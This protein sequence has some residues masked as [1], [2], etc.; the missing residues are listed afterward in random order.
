[1]LAAISTKGKL[2]F[3]AAARHNLRVAIGIGAFL[4]AAGI[5]LGALFGLVRR[6]PF[7]ARA[8]FLFRNVLGAA[9]VF[10][11]LQLVWLGTSGTFLS[12]LKQLFLAA[13][14]VL[15]GNWLGRL[16]RLQKI[17]NRL[18]HQAHQQ[19]VTAQTGA[20]VGNTDGFSAC[21]IL[22]CAAPLG[23]LGAVAD[24]LSG[25]FWLL[26]VKALME[27]LAMSAFV[28][29]F[30]W[31]SSLSAIPVFVFLAAITLAC[32]IYAKPYLDSQ[33]LT[34][35]ILCAT[36]LV[37]CAVSLVIF[38]TRRVELANYLPALVIAPL[39]AALFK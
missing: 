34:G 17:S 35:S 32:Q 11:G 13:L 37:T 14:A 28:K 29:L 10:F 31:P 39:L 3:A 27:G 15:L 2:F 20:R 38:E 4:N 16:L 25:Y 5:L 7:S 19:I 30:R 8:Q 6:E 1:M 21:A 36:G 9:T 12:V 23:I 33:H 26:A 18:G 24:G 22:F